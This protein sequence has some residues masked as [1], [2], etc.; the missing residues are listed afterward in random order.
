MNPS[1]SNV[2]IPLALSFAKGPLGEETF[3]FD[4]AHNIL[5]KEHSALSTYHHQTENTLPSGISKVMGNL[6]RH[7]AGSHFDYDLGS[8]FLTA[9][10]F[11]R[12]VKRFVDLLS[13]ITL[14][15]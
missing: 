1:Q 3:S 7:I 11:E 14:E 5:S 15:T 6:L 2:C 9:C 12:F 4:P 10:D 8:I 13:A